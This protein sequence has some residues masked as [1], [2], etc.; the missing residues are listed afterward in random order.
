MLVLCV[1][2]HDDS[3]EGA[4]IEDG[5]GVLLM[6]KGVVSAG[7]LKKRARRDFGGSEYF[8]FTGVGGKAGRKENCCNGLYCKF[9]ASLK[10][11]YADN[12]GSLETLFPVKPAQWL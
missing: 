12:T 11:A 3:W 5:R 9:Q 1:V 6:T 8:F 10:P 7:G 2:C 4:L